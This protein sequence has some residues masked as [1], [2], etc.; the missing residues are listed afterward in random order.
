L[1]A[2]L[3]RGRGALFGTGGGCLRHLLHL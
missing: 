2:Q 3:L 1:H